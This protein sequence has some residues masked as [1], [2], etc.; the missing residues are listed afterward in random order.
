MFDP[1][2]LFKSIANVYFFIKIRK[3]HHISGCVSAGCSPAVLASVLF[4][5][6][7]Y[8]VGGLLDSGAYSGVADSVS[9]A[10]YIG[11][12]SSGGGIVSPSLG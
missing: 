7:S 2:F 4:Y 10:Y 12:P 8:S 6:A 5:P 11:Y 9:G 1:P 3:Q